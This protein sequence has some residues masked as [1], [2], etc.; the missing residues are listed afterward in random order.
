MAETKL[1]AG[2]VYR[3][4]R[5]DGGVEE[6]VCWATLVRKGKTYGWI[7]RFGLARQTVEEGTEAVGNMV[8]IDQP[9][10]TAATPAKKMAEKPPAAKRSTTKKT[11]RRRVS[12]KASS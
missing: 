11:T 6:F 4:E 2:A 8:R 9:K 7:Q 5:E 1:K 3:I 10:P 12:S